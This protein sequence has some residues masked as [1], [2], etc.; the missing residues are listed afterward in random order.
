MLSIVA[1]YKQKPE[2]ETEGVDETGSSNAADAGDA[3]SESVASSEENLMSDNP[4]THSTT[5]SEPIGMSIETDDA[6]Q[7]S[8]TTSPASGE[9]AT[10]STQSE[11]IP[12]TIP[13]PEVSPVVE[14]SVEASEP[15]ANPEVS[16]PAAIPPVEELTN[17][18]DPV[19]E[20]TRPSTKSKKQKKKEQAALAEGGGG[21][22]TDEA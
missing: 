17:T 11:I 2:S 9:A 18:T 15:V 1:F 10:P 3:V 21:E 7:L 19:A 12:E 8:A 4:L 6:I 22:A 13:V 14:T 20:V 5:D 16:E